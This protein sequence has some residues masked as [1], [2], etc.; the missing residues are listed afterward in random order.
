MQL[1]NVGLILMRRQ[2]LCHVVVVVVVV[3]VVVATLLVVHSLVC[4]STFAAAVFG[5][6]T[7]PCNICV[8]AF[9]HFLQAEGPKHSALRMSESCDL[10]NVR[11]QQKR[12]ETQWQRGREKGSKANKHVFQANCKWAWHQPRLYVSQ[13]NPNI[14]HTRGT[15][16][17]MAS[18]RTHT[19]NVYV[20]V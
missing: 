4:Y 3:E 12:I 9:A 11:A 1:N 10:E 7:W 5:Y 15:E 6:P 19:H 18:H 8:C 17:I 16:N 14:N 13:Q 2:A 20:Y